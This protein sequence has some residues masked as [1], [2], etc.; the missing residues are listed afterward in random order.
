MPPSGRRGG[1]RPAPS[2]KSA[3]GDGD[4]SVGAE[5]ITTN[6]FF[7]NQPGVMDQTHG[8]EDL[9]S[10]PM[11]PDSDQL[12]NK[13]VLMSSRAPPPPRAVARVRGNAA[14]QTPVM[15]TPAAT[16]AATPYYTPAA[17]PAAIP[18]A[19]PAAPASARSAAGPADTSHVNVSVISDEND[20]SMISQTAVIGGQ[21]AEP[22]AVVAA[23]EPSQY[24]ALSMWTA[25]QQMVVAL[26]LKS[27]RRRLKKYKATISGKELTSKVHKWLRAR[28]ED[29]YK[30]ADRKQASKIC[31]LLYDQGLLVAA[32]G[33]VGLKDSGSHL[34]F[35]DDVTGSGVHGLA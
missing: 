13:S 33:Q 18:A 14:P 24:K 10:P 2:A 4:D 32:H 31:G 23:P 3:W 20:T 27:H 6:S 7:T 16:P 35:V 21:R 5:I 19:T 22:P 12:T 34:Y 15:A 30:K 29:R 1:A 25:L 8:D 11:S 17:T 28:E 26:K 9:P